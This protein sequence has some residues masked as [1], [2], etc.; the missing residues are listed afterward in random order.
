MYLDRQPDLKPL[1]EKDV[2][3]VVQAMRQTTSRKV[4]FKLM[5]R[6]KVSQTS[7]SHK[8]VLI[9][10]ARAQITE[11]QSPLRQ[12]MR[13]RGFSLMTNILDDYV[14]DLEIIQVVSHRLSHSFKGLVKLIK[15]L[16]A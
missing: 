2:P 6:V 10:F 14:K 7:S 16:G 12:L 8:I 11:D 4:L 9:G 5:T 13:L 1:L 15:F 3:K